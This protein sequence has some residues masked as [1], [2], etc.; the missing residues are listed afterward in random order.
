VA[1]QIWTAHHFAS[2]NVLHRT[3]YCKETSQNND[4]YLSVTDFCYTIDT[5]IATL[6]F[7][8]TECSSLVLVVVYIGCSI[9]WQEVPDAFTLM[10][11]LLNYVL[12]LTN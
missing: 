10:V 5:I 1:K 7:N 11:S 2:A 12:L 6:H 4:I 8:S 9:A 3:V